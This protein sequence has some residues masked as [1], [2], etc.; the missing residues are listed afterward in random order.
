MKKPACFSCWSAAHTVCMKCEHETECEVKSEKAKVAFLPPTSCFGQFHPDNR[1][2]QTCEEALKCNDS[3][4]EVEKPKGTKHDAGKL[5]WTL[6]T[7]DLAEQIESTVR[8]L[9]KG[10]KEHGPRNWQEKNLDDDRRW[11]AA[12][13]RHMQ[14]INKGEWLDDGED[15][16]GEPHLACIIVGALFR[17][18]HHDNRG[19]E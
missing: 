15:G 13:T 19:K 16:T 12:Q 3:R 1:A 11:T 14:A 7:V 10:A 18:W 2:C 4:R 9:S 6:L 17:M 5:D 8:V